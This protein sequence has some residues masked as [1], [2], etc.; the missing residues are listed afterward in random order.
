MIDLMKRTVDSRALGLDGQAGKMLCEAE[1]AK[2]YRKGRKGNP[3]RSQSEGDMS[4][5]APLCEIFALSAVRIF[6]AFQIVPAIAAYNLERNAK[7]KLSS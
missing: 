4:C 5:F 6:F 2:A 1:E 7:E 3:Q